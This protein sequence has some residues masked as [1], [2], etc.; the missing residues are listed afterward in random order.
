MWKNTEGVVQWGA[1]SGQERKCPLVT[2]Q[3]SSRWKNPLD[4][5]MKLPI[6]CLMTKGLGAEGGG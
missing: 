2:I 4:K 3:E 5:G 1:Y 6:K